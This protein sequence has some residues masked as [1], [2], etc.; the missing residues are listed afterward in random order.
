MWIKMVY[1]RLIYLTLLF[2]GIAA[3]S[4]K[5]D[6][7][8]SRFSGAWE[9]ESVKIIDYIDGQPALDTTYNNPGTWAFVDNGASSYTGNNSLM[10][11]K[12]AVPCIFSGALKA[13]GNGA[14]SGY[15]KWGADEVTEKRIAFDL[16]GTD[17]ILNVTR[18]NNRKFEFF[19]II[20]DAANASIKQKQE[21]VLKPTNG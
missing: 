7:I 12:E 10:V 15:I 1:R 8:R 11:L 19:H 20:R 13:D 16:G 5:K 21:Y 3:S 2:T 14:S 4:C 17:Y 9:I 18:I 6:R